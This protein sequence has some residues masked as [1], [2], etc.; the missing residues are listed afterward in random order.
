MVGLGWS[1]SASEAKAGS[2]EL[3]AGL[4]PLAVQVVL[5]AAAVVPLPHDQR[6]AEAI[7]NQAGEAFGP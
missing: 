1:A 2:Q 5:V 4:Q 3:A 6:P 7:G